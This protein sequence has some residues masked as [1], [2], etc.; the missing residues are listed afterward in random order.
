MYLYVRMYACY[1]T[2]Y[3]KT[4]PGCSNFSRSIM[5]K[6]RCNYVRLHTERLQLLL[7]LT[8][9]KVQYLNMASRAAPM[10]L[11][12][13]SCKSASVNLWH[14]GTSVI[15]LGAAWRSR[16]TRRTT[17]AGRRWSSRI[18]RDCRHTYTV[19][20]SVIIQR[21]IHTVCR[22][23]IC[24]IVLFSGSCAF[25]YCV[26]SVKRASQVLNDRL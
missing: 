13:K 14:S 22:K 17:L 25:H 9:T 4:F 24:D 10:R 6:H 12:V 26:V 8:T 18:S 16:C 7:W 23:Q 5:L 20:I 3:S 2:C 11:R 15:Q 1:C 21:H 19:N